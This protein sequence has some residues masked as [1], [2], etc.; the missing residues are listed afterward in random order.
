ML[1]IGI[2]ATG[3]DTDLWSILTSIEEGKLDAEVCVVVS[4]KAMAK[5][6]GCAR[7]NGIPA[8]YL[9]PTQFT[10]LEAYDG[11]VVTTMNEH[12]VELV[13]MA[14]WLKIISQVLAESFAGRMISFHPSLLP[15][16]GGAGMYGKNVHRAV[17]AEGVKIS[18][19]T[20][21]FVTFEI[22][23]GAII[24]Q[25]AIPVFDDDTIDSLAARVAEEERKLV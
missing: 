4:H 6:L 22:D 10:T 25:T 12:G 7:E 20:A 13:V 16:F 15:A 14:N 23:A 2:M 5:A 9:D 19:C 3:S 18:G 8:V 1:R 11:A 21:H 24:A 17:L